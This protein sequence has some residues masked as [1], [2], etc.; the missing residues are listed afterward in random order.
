MEVEAEV[1]LLQGCNF[2]LLKTVSESVKPNTWWSCLYLPRLFVVLYF[3][4]FCMQITFCLPCQA[5]ITNN[6]I[7]I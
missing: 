2:D 1:L 4:K 6:C 3:F 5:E 7:S